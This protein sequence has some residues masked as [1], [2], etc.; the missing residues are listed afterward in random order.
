MRTVEEKILKHFRMKGVYGLNIQALTDVGK[1]RKINEDSYIY[2]SCDKYSYAMVADGMGGHLAGEVAS[3][4]AVDIVSEYIQEHITDDL[5]HFQVK[6]ILNRAFLTANNQIYDYSCENESVMGMGTTATLCLIR[7]RFLIYAHIGDSRAYM[8]DD[9]AEQ[10]TRDHSYV[11]ELVKL[12]QITPEEAKTHP[13]RNYIT[14]AMGVEKDV[15]ADLGIK[16]YNGEKVLICSDGLHG[17]VEDW[18]LYKNAVELTTQSCVEEL[19]RLA[20]D[21]GGED[22]ITV[23]VMEGEDTNA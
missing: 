14:R 15:R 5:D 6:E 19:V 20:N 17:K 23:V 1:V 10:I 11:Q 4:M 9:K 22:N 12:G 16:T 18:E 3:K 21:R 8:I 2:F 7:D 13:R